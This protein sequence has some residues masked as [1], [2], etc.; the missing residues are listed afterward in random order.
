MGT[1]KLIALHEGSLIHVIVED[2]GG[3][4]DPA[5][6]GR[7]AVERGLLAEDERASMTASRLQSLILR[8]GFSTAEVV[9]DLSG[10]GVGLD[11]VQSNIEAIG[12]SLQIESE[13]GQ[14]TKFH[15]RLPLTLAII[16]CLVVEAGEHRLCVPQRDIKELVCWMALPRR[17]SKW[18]TTAKSSVCGINLFPWLPWRNCSDRQLLIQMHPD[19]WQWYEAVPGA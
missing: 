8:P 3:G 6:V 16:P 5:K 11:V 1:V 13:L 4:I 18:D 2:D 19:F 12:G 10:R 14:G 17:V 9:T 15:L 7:K